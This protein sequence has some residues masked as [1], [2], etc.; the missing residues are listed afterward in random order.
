[1]VA[2][3]TTGPN[4]AQIEH[5][6]GPAGETWVKLQE[7][8]DGQLAPLGRKAMDRAAIRPGEKILDVG[9]GTGQTTLELAGR[10]GRNG[11]V[12]GVDVSRP[13]LA[14]ARERA[15]AAAVGHARF[16]QGDAQTHK[17]APGSF[18]L[19]FSR[20]GIMFFA[21]PVAAFG[22]LRSA[23]RGQGRM[24]FV[25]WRPAQDNEWMTVPMAA[26]FRHIPRPPA[27]APGAPGEFAF[28]D[29]DR[30]HGILSGAGFGDILIEPLDEMIGGSSLDVT[31]DTTLSMGP[32]AA[33]LR[34][35]GSEK[36]QAVEAALRE[37]L[38]P[39][40]GPGGVRM[41][42]AA[43]IVSARAP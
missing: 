14:L 29:R 12:L 11:A 26:A 8:L 38:A 39:F 6:N 13:M 37:A 10:V 28:A 18:D 34:E 42:S 15:R 3:A 40:A 1:M 27:S 17:F 35:A 20:F 4:A 30:V 9:C 19:V 23:L 22:N 25:C 33:A 5:W 2:L 43:W 32:V 7:R 21:D 41:G 16:E 36:R 31:I 24:V